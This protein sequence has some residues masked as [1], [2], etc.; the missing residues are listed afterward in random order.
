MTYQKTLRGQGGQA[1]IEMALVVTLLVTLSIGILEVGRAFMILNM[2]TN[3]TRDGARLAA[4]AG[5]NSRDASGNLSDPTKTAIHDQVVAQINTV[6]AQTTVST[7]A[8]AMFNQTTIGTAPNTVPVVQITVSGT[9]PLMFNLL[10]GPIS[11][12][13]VASFRDEGK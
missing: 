2:I 13:R 10:G 8:T 3:A 5:P 4:G 6:D 9:V 12:T 11:F 7:A 1:M